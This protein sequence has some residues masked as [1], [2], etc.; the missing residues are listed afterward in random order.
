MND[1]VQRA[2]HG[3]STA[4]VELM[5]RNKRPLWS[6]AIAVLDNVEDAADALQ[7][8]TI[9]AWRAIP[10]FE[11]RSTINTWL[12]RI[13]LRAC[14]DALRK[15][16]HETPYAMGGET[17]DA[18]SPTGSLLDPFRDEFRVIAGSK[19]AADQDEALDVRSAVGRLSAD[20][21]L[22]LTLFYVDDYPV[23]HIASILNASEG[24]VRT[25]LSRARDKFKIAYGG[26]DEEKAE[27]AR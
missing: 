22:L 1:L 19:H 21:R 11:G 12:M 5:E 8:A 2:Q 4:F 26:E 20:D 3:D 18:Y 10:R 6:A 24:A 9:K 23:Q 13:L 17:S 14:Y 25:R 16:S 27:V 7:E 15:R